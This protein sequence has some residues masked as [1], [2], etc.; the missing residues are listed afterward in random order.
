M[1]LHKNP[2]RYEIKNDEMKKIHVDD[3]CRTIDYK[4]PSDE[5]K[6]MKKRNSPA[7]EKK[8]AEEFER[9]KTGNR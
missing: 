4:I 2:K 6:K 7:S 1:K 5:I 8:K 9:K 3:L